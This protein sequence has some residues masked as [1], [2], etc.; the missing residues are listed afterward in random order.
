MI[1]TNDTSLVT[2]L[3]A[4]DPDR[5]LEESALELLPDVQGA[6]SFVFMD[7]HALYAARDPQGIR[8]LVLGRLENGWVVASE[9]AALA[10]VGARVVREIEPGELVVIDD[11]GLRSHQFARAGAEGLRLRVRLPRPPRRHHRRP[12][13]PRGAGRDGPAAGQGLP[14]RGATW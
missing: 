11:D 3:L 2:T 7:E 1:A 10:T 4:A 6:F 13:R 8:P 9:D 5:T 12:Q 14:R